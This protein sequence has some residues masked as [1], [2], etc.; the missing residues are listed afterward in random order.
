MAEDNSLIQVPK[1][2]MI[3]D[4]NERYGAATQ[5]TVARIQSRDLAVQGFVAVA[6]TLLTLALTKDGYRFIAV[7]VGYVALAAALLSGHHDIVIGLLGL[8]QFRLCRG[9]QDNIKAQRD[10][11]NWFSETYYDRTLQARHLRDWYFGS[12]VLVGGSLSLVVSHADTQTGEYHFAK[13]VIW[14]L[15]ACC[16][17][18]AFVYIRYV[19]RRRAEFHEEMHGHHEQTIQKDWGVIVLCAAALTV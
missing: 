11:L 4:G 17:L 14:Y 13:L 3:V 8:Y 12:M 16:V 1:D 7:S 5:E 9:Q 10:N 18:A 2:P 19:Y 15:S 6:G